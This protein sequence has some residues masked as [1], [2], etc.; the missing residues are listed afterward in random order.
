MRI[1]KPMVSPFLTRSLIGP[2]DSSQV[3]KAAKAIAKVMM[4]ANMGTTS[5]G[6]RSP[7]SPAITIAQKK[8]GI[9]LIA[10]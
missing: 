6:F 2:L 3:K 10:Q 7:I 5:K 9:A 4:A 1:R 8:P